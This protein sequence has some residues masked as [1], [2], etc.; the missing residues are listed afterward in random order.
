MSN[1]ASKFWE[2]RVP[3][4]KAN[5]SVQTVVELI[6]AR[7][8]ERYQYDGNGSGCLTWSAK[9]LADYVATEYVRAIPDFAEFIAK[10]RKAEAS[11]NWI[12]D[13]QGT[14]I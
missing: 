1:P 8:R 10:T 14:Y 12:P 2:F 9:L 3:V 11:S 6:T 4:I 13:D 5:L 7:G